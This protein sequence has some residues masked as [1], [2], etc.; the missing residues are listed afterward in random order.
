MH[1]TGSRAWRPAVVLAGL[2]TAA[3][4]LPCQSPAL[5]DGKA[6]GPAMFQGRPYEGSV[7]ERSQEAIIIFHGSRTAGEARE[8]VILKIGVTG[9]VENFAW[10]VP[11]PD[12]PDVAK[13]DDKLFTELYDY[14]QAR[15][16]RPAKKDGS[17][18]A[19]D[20][21]P[22][23]DEA[24]PAVEVLSRKIVGTF[25]V[26]VVREN[27]AGALN[28]WLQENGYQ[29][30][31]GADDVLDF[32][33]RK[34]YVYACVK[35]SE[36]KLSQETAVE[37]HPLR[38][39]FKTGGRDGIYFP[40]KMTG[41]QQEPFDVN[42]YVFYKAWINDRLSKFGYEHRGFKREYRDWDS[43]QCKPNAGKTYSTPQQDVFLADLAGRLPTVTRLFQKLHPGE[44]YYLTNIQARRLEPEAIRNWSDD[45]WLFPYYRNRDFIPYDARPEGP[46]SA[47]WPGSVPTEKKKTS[48]TRSASSLLAGQPWVPP[49][50]GGGI[51]VILG[52]GL[53][54]GV[55]RFRRS[56]HGREAKP[57][58]DV[59]ASENTMATDH[60]TV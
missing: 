30:L 48:K 9:G 8:D 42:L 11:F 55:G 46:A 29:Q 52:M 6:I 17:K 21:T 15:M 16:A 36:V 45:L 10:V 1:T 47:A 32:Y 58:P 23:A 20:D 43:S 34:K 49:A 3:A 24:R 19:A 14:V 35:V 41:L 5:A 38:F 7:E 18:A 57:Q 26:A 12:K 13:E 28:G 60:G 4:V 25:D 51:G 53:I 33:R 2:L 31:D 59:A 44:R 27:E 50:L 54:L 56:R 37:L 40:M 22:A 39:T